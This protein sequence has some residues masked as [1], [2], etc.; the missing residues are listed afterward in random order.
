MDGLTSLGEPGPTKDT[1]DVNGQ[2]VA[3]SFEMSVRSPRMLPVPLHRIQLE[4]SSSRTL[5]LR[6]SL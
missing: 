6:T 2:N 1:T 5:P 4:G 3:V